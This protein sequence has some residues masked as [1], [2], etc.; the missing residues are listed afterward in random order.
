MRNKVNCQGGFIE[1]KQKQLE[2]NAQSVH[3]IPV[4]WIS[5]VSRLLLKVANASKD[6]PKRFTLVGMYLS[7]ANSRDTYTS[8][9][10]QNRTRR[11]G[12]FS[13][14]RERA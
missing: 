14:N 2:R 6:R 11:N 8:E 7:H 1:F 5:K 3:D 12:K 10:Q 9:L 4:S 13:H